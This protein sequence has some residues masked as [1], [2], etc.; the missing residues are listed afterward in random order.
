MKDYLE[1]YLELFKDSKGTN[2]YV[3]D[4]LVGATLLAYKKFIKSNDQ[5]FIFSPNSYQANELYKSL[6]S[7]IDKENIVLLTANELIRADYIS[8]SSELKSEMIYGLYRIRRGDHIVVIVTPASLL[9]F[10]PSIET[11]DKNTITFK[12]GDKVNFDN[13]K[14]L[15][16]RMGYIRVNKI[17][18]SL[19]YAFRGG[20]IDVF[21]INYEHPIRIDLFDDEIESIKF[22]NI[23]TQK[24]FKEVD[25][26]VLLPGSLNLLNEDELAKA[27]NKIEFRLN[28]D[29]LRIENEEEKEELKA[30]VLEDLESILKNEI[31]N[32]NYK[33]MGVLQGFSNNLIDFS[34]NKSIIVASKNEFEDAKNNLINESRNFLMELFENRKALSRL[35]YFDERA[36]LY[37]GANEVDFLDNFHKPDSD[38]VID[39]RTI[40]ITYGRKNIEPKD[41]IAFYTTQKYKIF[42]T[43]KDEQE[44]TSI[45]LILKELNINYFYDEK[46]DERAHEETDVCF[47]KTDHP[48]NFED[49]LNQK[50]YL[51]TSFVL[52]KREKLNI[53]T[54]K[55]KEGKILESYEELEEGDYVVHEK[56]GIG[57]FSHI[58]TIEIEGK[59]N[60]YIEILYANNDKLYIPLYQFNLI[61]KYVGKEGT[62]PKLTNIGTKQREK[63][64]KKIKERID[65]LADRL[66]TLY[67]ER[68][69]VPGFAFFKDDEIQK[70]F[71]IDFDYDLTKDQARCVKEIK[72]DMEKPTP[73]DRL[74]CGDVGF[75]KTEVAFEAAMKA[76]LS[77]KQVCFLCP[78]TLLAS[79]HYKVA[80]ERFAKY[81]VRIALLSRMTSYY[82]QKVIK[83]DVAEGK[84]D[85][86]IG[87]HKVLGST[88][89]FKNLGFLIV[90]EE[91]RFGVEQKEVLKERYKNIDVLTLSATPIPRTLQS[92]LVGLKN[93]STIDTPPEGRL[94]I[95]TYVINYDEKVI[96]EIIERELGRHG[97]VY[98]LYNDI[99]TLFKRVLVLQKM[100]PNAKIA[101][102]HARME[103]DVIE[104]TMQKFYDGEVDILVATTIIENGIDVRNANLLIV[105]NADR[106][107]LAQ[108]YQIKGRVGRG[109]KLAF[110]YLLTKENKQMTDEAK[111]RLKAIQDFTELGSGY[112]IAQRDLLIR[113]AGDILGPEQAGFIDSVGVDMYIKLLNETIE[114]KKGNKITH[115]DIKS[116][117]S[118][119]GY[120]PK[121]FA[122]D[123]DKLEIYQRILNIKSIV[124]LED[125][126]ASI[127]D[128]F[129]KIPE[130]LEKLFVKRAV[131]IYLNNEEFQGYN[132]YPKYV[133]LILSEKFCKI[134][135]IGTS[136]FTSLIRYTNKIRMSY[137]NKR[138]VIDI[139]KKDDWI[140][141]LLVVLKNVNRIYASERKAKNVYEN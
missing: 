104:D 23:E 32:K 109:D 139:D 17:D 31:S 78:T 110:A 99:A 79:Q 106:F 93:I 128:Q 105:E 113:G 112:K 47:L 8:E 38:T 98:Y 7:V 52:R 53:Y 81:P 24:S 59:K 27:K 107:G 86:L 15:L 42:I 127:R 88:I 117:N 121:E 115:T 91:Q 64:K 21:S 82:K 12:V 116:L 71:E 108:L 120:I 62:V 41:L 37:V 85:L 45:K 77:G 22:F 35:E 101:A 39:L 95:Q 36:K 96:K 140:D 50:V 102:I 19:E 11:F 69:R 40:Q 138:I 94:P 6:Q 5:I 129:G 55:F 26:C 67:Q 119:E 61:R 18:Q 89:N 73:M 72:E 125:L 134:E 49:Y 65:D 126:H 130:G 83:N 44:L 63:T 141:T 58:D 114:E 30:N 92:S 135:G 122:N 100:I 14:S 56:Y 43:F 97:Q 54:S 137:L 33:Y 118:L 75:G 9:R 111:K 80:C 76:I 28:E 10:Y 1:E 3:V 123:N 136:L 84:I 16:S 90:D 124:M 25:E 29:L 103:K 60:D 131:D 46:G 68:S 48:T 66:L 20:V 2:S 87:T 57:K 51:T 13:L 34:Q 132:E 4:P 74:L 70:S 133:H